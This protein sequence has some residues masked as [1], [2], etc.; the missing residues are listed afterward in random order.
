MNHNTINND[1]AIPN[2]STTPISGLSSDIVEHS[3][4]GE[5]VYELMSLCIANKIDLVSIVAPKVPELY[6]GI[7][8]EKFLL[9]KLNSYSIEFVFILAALA[10][11]ISEAG[12]ISMASQNLPL[13]ESK[14]KL[15]IEFLETLGNTLFSRFLLG[16]RLDIK[17]PESSS[18]S[19]DIIYPTI[20]QE[21]PHW[22][23]IATTSQEIIIPKVL[24]AFWKLEKIKMKQTG[25]VEITSDNIYVFEYDI[26][27]SNAEQIPSGGLFGAKQSE[28]Y[29]LNKTQDAFELIN[30]LN[31]DLL[32]NAKDTVRDAISIKSKALEEFDLVKN[33]VHKQKGQIHELI[34]AKS[35]LEG[36]IDFLNNKGNQLKEESSSWKASK[37]ASDQLKKE[38]EEMAQI[39][40]RLMSVISHELRTP[41]SS[42]LGFTEL[43]LEC[44]CD[45]EE[46]KEYISTIYNESRR[47]KD[48]LDEF[49]DSQRLNSGRIELHREACDMHDVLKYIVQAFKGYASGVD[50]LVDA[51]TRLPAVYADKSKLEQILRNFV[52]NAIKYSP[53]GGEVRITCS[54]D[55][56]KVIICVSDQGLGI[57]EESLPK[58][59]TDFYRVEKETHI[60]I[61]G[62]GLGLSITKQLI[63]AHGGEIW[64]KSK[65]NV[66]SQFYFSIPIVQ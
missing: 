2:L 28:E 17:N 9:N 32:S 7:I 49:L 36:I 59:F 1:C 48:L 37:V 42:L 23:N 52:S 65:L 25:R 22:K 12:I 43:L 66:G 54:L 20:L 61:K 27:W 62:T 18:G 45:P 63:E 15:P 57:P 44:E 46:T 31:T 64:V 29:I 10:I 8:T 19:I 60:N 58:L 21:I 13:I 35:E 16:A 26:S 51:P 38:A 55:N 4:G 5:W 47:M 50:I 39:K 33:I 41:L 56:N 11:E 40:S 24:N 34:S 14:Y 30:N 53:D 3:V 6:R